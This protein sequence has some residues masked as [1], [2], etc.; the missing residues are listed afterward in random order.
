[1]QFFSFAEAKPIKYKR[2][3]E[4]GKIRDKKEQSKASKFIHRIYHYVQNQGNVEAKI[5]SLR[6]AAIYI[7]IGGAWILFSD[8]VLSVM[9]KDTHAFMVIQTY[10]G[11]LYVFVTGILLYYVVKKQTRV[12]F[13]T[14]Q[15][16][17][18]S[19][20]KAELANEK[21]KAAQEKLEEQ[22]KVLTQNQMELKKTEERYRLAIEGANDAIWDW[23]IQRED[24]FMFSRTKE[25]LGYEEDELE[26]RSKAWNSL[27]HPDDFDRVVEELYRHLEG[28]TPY[29]QTE[30]RVRTK[31]GEYK[32][33]L[34]RGKAIRD[35]DGKPIRMAGSHTDITE[36]KEKEEK[37]YEL[38][39][40]DSL[41]RLPNRT[42]FDKMLEQ[43]IHEA[44][45]TNRKVIILMIDL[46]D[47]KTVNNTLGPDYGDMV[48]KNT[49]VMLSDIIHTKGTVA[50][51]GGD[52]FGIII[53]DNGDK[54]DIE[55][56]TSE[57]KE[58]FQVSWHIGDYEFYI[59]A[60]IGITVFPDD[61]QDKETLLKHASTAMYEAKKVGKNTFCF[62]TKEMNDK[63]IATVKLENELR[64]ALENNQLAIYYQPQIDLK[65]GQVVGVEALLRWI[66]PEKGILSPDQFVWIAEY[67]GLIV[68]IGEWV[69]EMVSNQYNLWKKIYQWDLNMSVNLSMK[70]LQHY[71]FIDK[72]HNIIN[73]THMN[74]KKLKFE[75]T[76][77]IVMEDANT[78]IAKL[79][80]LKKMGIKIA[81][82]DFGTGYSSLNYLRELPIDVLKIDKSFVHDMIE[83]FHK[84]AIVELIID[85]AHKMNMTVIAEGVESSE[86]ISYLSQYRCDMAQ[87]YFVS[88]PLSKEEFELFMNMNGGYCRM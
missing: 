87:G 3:D 65:T 82:D 26:N 57:L 78:T 61:G 10:K 44:Y 30:H 64:H 13:E 17:V 32:W 69:M 81:L 41:I 43:A 25:M 88:Q 15:K 66:H 22:L 35:S 83:N 86:Q 50:R 34:A 68:P 71:D 47:F 59:T 24:T 76:E 56:I 23:D 12:I 60:S 80:Q 37:I 58:A 38:A 53:Y 48:L 29:Y 4:M 74:C 73:K 31:S 79:R 45:Q 70:Q 39:Y 72:I 20:R 16:L 19:H 63:L 6:I 77:S 75:I 51:T 33:I 21:L 18:E 2:C 52:E 54:Y 1:M 40:Y 14:Q 9:I 7:V 5:L 85:L 84:R 67:T 49:S 11:W 27:I 42:M 8:R 55:K 62:Y 36:R 28:K 46:D